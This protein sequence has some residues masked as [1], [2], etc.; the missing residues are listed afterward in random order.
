MDRQN[1]NDDSY[2]EGEYFNQQ[3]FVEYQADAT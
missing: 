2:G 3:E 1:I